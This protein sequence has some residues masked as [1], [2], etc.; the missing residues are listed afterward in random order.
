MNILF[1]TADQWRGN[2]LS[3]LG[4]PVIE[5]PNLDKLA[6]EGVLFK[7]HYAQATPCSP[8][9]TSLHTGMYLHNHR[10]CLN[11]TPLD[12]KNTNWAQEIH[13]AGHHPFLFGYTDTAMDPRGL[14]EDDPRL[15]HYSEP[16]PGI[17][18]ETVYADEVPLNWVE[19]LRSRGYAIPS[20]LWDLYSETAEKSQSEGDQSF[21][22]ALKIGSEDHETGYMVNQCIDWITQQQGDWVTHLSIFRP[23]PPFVAPEPYNNL[24]NPDQLDPV[25][26]QI[27]WQTEA[28]QH[29]WLAYQLGKEKFLAPQCQDTFNKLKSSYYG[30]M[31]EVDDYLGILFDTIRNLGQWDDTLIIFTSDHGE[32]MGD[33]WLMS[34]S[35]YFDSSYHIPLIIRDPRS[36]ADSSRGR[37]VESFTENVDIMPTIL[38]SLGLD[39]PGQCDGYSLLPFVENE[40][41]PSGWRREVHWEYDFRDILDN[42]VETELNLTQ[43][44]CSLNVIR[45]D[46]FKYVHFTTLPALFF[47]LEKDP[48]ELNNVAEDPSYQKQILI[49]AQKLISWRMN[50]DDRGL[51]ETYLS[52]NGPVTRPSPRHQIGL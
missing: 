20:T 28:S 11:G 31:K 9:R 2:C 3:A 35:G 36:T 6:S 25:H 48:H 32:Q 8:S 39:I 22:S 43:H 29:P 30:L 42:R 50:H 47:D 38:G 5:T 23:H 26:R 21:P 51:T 45:D 17:K 52:E 7:K 15:C 12:A 49:Y 27:N 4:H 34:K 1:I 24:Y 44:Q 18:T 33:H 40:N 37:Q 10:V 19:H 13:Q 41:A 46:H 16:L 14:S